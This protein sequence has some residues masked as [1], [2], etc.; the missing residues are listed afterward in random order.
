MY[1]TNLS[2]GAKIYSIVIYV[3][4][5]KFKKMYPLDMVGDGGK[6]KITDIFGLVEQILKKNCLDM[7][8]GGKKHENYSIHVL[9]RN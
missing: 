7:S 3:L 6:K 9:W 8:G 4:L 2:D 5:I 1:S